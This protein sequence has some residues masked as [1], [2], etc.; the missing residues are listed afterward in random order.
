MTQSWDTV[1]VRISLL[2]LYY[3]GEVPLGLNSKSRAFSGVPTPGTLSS[4]T[5]P[6]PFEAVKNTPQPCSGFLERTK[7]LRAKAAPKA[8]FT[9]LNFHLLLDLGL[10]ILHKL[11]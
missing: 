2:N 1:F 4:S 10:V 11:H 3:Y 6:S 8:W 9:T 5:L 7:V